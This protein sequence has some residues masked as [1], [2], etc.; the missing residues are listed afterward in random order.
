MSLH[1]R[2][3]AV[4]T[5]GVGSRPRPLRYKA[6]TVQAQQRPDRQSLGWRA[7]LFIAG[8]SAAGAGLVAW[9][10][11]RFDPSD[12][13][14]LA[15]LTL[16]A[17]LADRL[18]VTIYDETHLSVSFVPLFAVAVLYGP[19]GVAIAGPI[20]AVAVH[21][22]RQVFSL[23]LPFD[24]GNVT[25]AITLAAVS[26]EGMA[27]V[28]RDE[29]RP[30]ML[31]AA[32]TAGAVAYAVNAYL[33]SQVASL[34]SG[35]SVLQVWL[36]KGRW[37]FP[38]YVV[39]GLLGLALALA[40]HALGITGLLAFVAPP[41]MMQLSIKQYVERT[42]ETVTA[43]RR[44]N[45]ELGE[46]NSEILAM[47]KT[48]RDTYDGT[49]E[50][51]V[52]ALDARDRETKGHSSR[53]TE[54]TL[55]IARCLG[56]QPETPAWEDLK[57]AG[58]LHDVGKIGVSDF[59]LHKPGPLTPEE[60]EEMRRHPGIGYEMLRGVRFLA[61]PAE[62]VLSHHE[63]FDGK[64]YPRALAGDEIPLGARIF[65]VADTFDAMTSDRPYRRALPWETARDEIVRHSG[66]QFDPQ[67]V[68]A[69]L[70]AY[71]EWVQRRIKEKEAVVEK[72]RAA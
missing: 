4:G 51:L 57:R 32:L 47:T 13:L 17:V 48:L 11:P 45:E 6:A 61:G 38:H 59:I 30:I 56:L 18:A 22:P 41:L 67:A 44:K 5:K 50:A 24:V 35:R 49:L 62:I 3:K 27:G 60:W 33:V 34:T 69:F 25:I 2:P 40:Y 26:F 14:G 19:P 36:E 29:I 39:F 52:T 43:L 66:T 42:M 23:R 64:G 31:P 12:A 37:L 65:A 7:V 21:I 63:R 15:L 20:A 70:Q 55:D 9:Y 16:L 1:K 53:V 28:A 10:A 54:Y 68:G 58:L 71:E 72:R 46:A 8:V